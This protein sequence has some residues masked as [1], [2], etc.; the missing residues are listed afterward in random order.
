MP[1]MKEC[2]ECAHHERQ[3]QVEERSVGEQGLDVGPAGGRVRDGLVDRVSG[4]VQQ[5]SLTDR[6]H[7][8]AARVSDDGCK[9]SHEGALTREC[10]CN[11]SPEVGCRENTPTQ[12]SWLVS[13]L[14]ACNRFVATYM[15][16][17]YTLL[18]TWK[19]SSP[20]PPNGSDEPE[21]DELM[22]K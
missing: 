8:D 7:E 18:N 21:M 10:T 20:A 19:I 14:S 9:V 16:P 3:C 11:C 22:R 17:M 13:V 12:R 5:Q 2:V 4:A 6:K 15:S 1:A